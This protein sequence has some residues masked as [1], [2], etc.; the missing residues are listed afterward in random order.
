M[1]H[2]AGFAAPVLHMD[3]LGGTGFRP[4]LWVEVTGHW[5]AKLAAI[6][7]HASQDPERF[8]V[9]AE[10][11]AAF[12][13]GECNG[14]PGARAEGFR[15]APRFPFADIRALVPPPPPLRPVAARAAAEGG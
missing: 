1:L 8:V 7:A 2:A 11:Q 3:V 9:M 4:G 12:R 10:R 15:H 14:P 13:A 6:R 5:P